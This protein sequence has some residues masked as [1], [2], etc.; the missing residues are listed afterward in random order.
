MSTPS[1]RKDDGKSD[2]IIDL[3]NLI[4]ALFGHAAAARV[5]EILALAE[6]E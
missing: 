1:R 6:E 2:P 3:Y 4:A 5:I